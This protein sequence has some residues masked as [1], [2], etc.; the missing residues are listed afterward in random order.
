MKDVV[1]H[2]L[3]LKKFIYPQVYESVKKNER[4]QQNIKRLAEIETDNIVED[5]SNELDESEVYEKML[6]KHGKRAI[7]ILKSMQS[8]LNHSFLLATSYVLHKA[9]PRIL[10]GIT[11]NSN[12]AKMLVDAKKAMPGKPFVFLP[13]HRSHLDYILLT[14]YLF[15]NNIRSPLVAAGENLKIPVFG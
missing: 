13:L 4:V 9:F 7:E 5:E 14:F 12:K 3:S 1:R 8:N 11:I 10:S 2:N 15:N 6:K